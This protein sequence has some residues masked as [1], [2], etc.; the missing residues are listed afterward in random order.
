MSK[1]STLSVLPFSL[2]NQIAVFIFN[3]NFYFMK[4]ASVWVLI[5][6]IPVCGS[7]GVVCLE[8]DIKIFRV[9]FFQFRQDKDDEVVYSNY[10]IH[11]CHQKPRFKH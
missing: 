9:I 8:I 3:L 7:K 5:S 6:T 1:G 11:T 4:T 2:P 10:Y